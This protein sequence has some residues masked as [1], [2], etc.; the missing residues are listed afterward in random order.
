MPLRIQL[1]LFQDLP[2]VTALEQC[3]VM[4]TYYVQHMRRLACGEMVTTQ[5]HDGPA[6]ERFAHQRFVFHEG[7]PGVRGEKAGIAGYAQSAVSRIERVR[8][9]SEPA[10][11]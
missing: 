9:L 3:V 6:L 11:D 10:R 1:Q 2:P 8:F 5:C 7:V 4:Q